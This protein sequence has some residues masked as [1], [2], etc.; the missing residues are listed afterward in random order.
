MRLS[1]AL[2]RTAAG[3]AVILALIAGTPAF[4]ADVI[5]KGVD[6][7]MT[8]AGFAQ[9]SFADQPIPAGFF[10][11]SSQ[12]FT[13]R[14]VLK[15]EPLAVAPVDSLGAIDTVVS[16][17]DDAAFDAKGEATTRIQLM[18]LS[19]VS[20][21]PIETSCGAYDVAIS[22]AGQQPTT[23]MRIFKTDALGGTYSAPLSLNVRAVFMPVDGNPAG[24]REVTRRIELGPGSHSVWTYLNLP[25][26]PRGVKVDTDGDGRP[27]TV[28]PA[29]SNFLAGVSPA[30]LKTA[31]ALPRLAA[32]TGITCPAGQCPYQSCHC[33]AQ[34]TNPPPAWNQSS[35]GCAADHLHCIWTCAPAGASA[36]GQPATHCL[37][38]K[39]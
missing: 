34:D 2:L 13:G 3:T 17:L 36:V 24:R 20:A 19:M 10:C 27:D 11:E 8:V 4:G 15:G 5:H 12:P 38:P 32:S 23:T 14:V 35:T 29:S 31:S 9:T 39:E 18:A 33:T 21:K 26:Y 16:R 1:S 28:L 30:V 25:R 37:S 22:L 7:W 6:L